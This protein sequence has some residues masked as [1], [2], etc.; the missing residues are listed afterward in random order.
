MKVAVLTRTQ[1][2]YV[3]EVPPDPEDGP[4]SSL[5][6]AQALHFALAAKDASHVQVGPHVWH[7]DEVLHI[8]PWEGDTE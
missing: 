4:A 1:G 7:K 8:G 5:E 2:E 6:Y 3:V